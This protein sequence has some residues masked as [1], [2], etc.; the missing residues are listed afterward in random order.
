MLNTLNIKHN[1]LQVRT[2]VRPKLPK[3]R[4]KVHDILQTKN[5]KTYDGK[6]FLLTNDAENW[7]YSL[8]KK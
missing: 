8:A 4:Q 1:M 5:I 7:V 6:Q 2:L 3:N